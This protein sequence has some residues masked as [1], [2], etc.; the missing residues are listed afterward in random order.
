[1]IRMAILVLAVGVAGCASTFESAT[2]CA[3]TAGCASSFP[4]T[5]YGPIQAQAA[6]PQAPSRWQ[7]QG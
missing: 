5:G 3:H 6:E 7:P 1:M 2:E 4:S